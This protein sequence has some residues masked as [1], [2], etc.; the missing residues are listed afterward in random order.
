[1]VVSSG[2]EGIARLVPW[3]WHG[4]PEDEWV[5]DEVRLVGDDKPGGDQGCSF[6]STGSRQMTSVM[7]RFLRRKSRI[8]VLYVPDQDR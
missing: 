4:E 5:E 7:Y 8:V 1:M 3:N 2:Y 6:A